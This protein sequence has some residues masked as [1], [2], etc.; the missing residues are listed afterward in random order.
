MLLAANVRV[1]TD[2]SE[3]GVIETVFV[4]AFV[5]PFLLRLLYFLS[6]FNPSEVQ[7]L[8]HLA[9]AMMFKTQKDLR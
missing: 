7:A 4:L 5:F 6:A 1:R 3:Y 9:L 2:C 8:L